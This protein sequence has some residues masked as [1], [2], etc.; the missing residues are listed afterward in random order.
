LQRKIGR[1]GEGGAMLYGT[2][3][4]LDGCVPCDVQR[5]EC[6]PFPLLLILRV[7]S[8]SFTGAQGLMHASGTIVAQMVEGHC[9]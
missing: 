4:V 3:T 8:I 6:T 1:G 5:H 9:T 7:H 2:R